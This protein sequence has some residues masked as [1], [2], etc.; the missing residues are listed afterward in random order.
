MPTINVSEETY[1]RIK[2]FKKVID[3][4]IGEEMSTMDEY[5]DLILS[6]GMQKM[7]MDVIPDDE[8]L[9]NTILTMFRDNP[10]YLCSFV[11]KVLK[12][13]EKKNIEKPKEEWMVAYR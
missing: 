12:E 8:L 5:A 9:R 1:E 4:V 2:H 6:V 10:E 11:A 13:G 7:M 3:A